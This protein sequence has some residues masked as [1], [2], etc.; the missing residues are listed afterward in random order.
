MIK[1]KGIIGTI[2]VSI[3][4][5]MTVFV[6]N[7][8]AQCDA[9]LSK[10][11]TCPTSNLDATDPA[12]DAGVWSTSGSAG[13]TTPASPSSQVT[14]LVV[15]TNT[16]TWTVAALGCSDQVDIVFS[17]AFAGNDKTVCETTQ[18]EGSNPSPGTGY[19][20]SS[21]LSVIFDDSTNPTA[22]VTN[23]PFGTVT[24]TW[25]VTIEGCTSTDD[26]VI[27]NS[28]PQ[29]V[30][31]GVS[32]E[33][34]ADTFQLSA[35]DPALYG[36]TGQWL[37]TGG[38]G[39][40][41]NSTL[42]NT[43]VR[44]LTAGNNTFQWTESLNGCP[45]S[46]LVVITYNDVNATASNQTI[47]NDYVTL[48]GNQPAGTSGLWTVI[49]STGFINTPTLRNTD[50][51]GLNP[52]ANT[53]KWTLTKGT[54]SDFVD[55]TI[56][57]DALFADAGPDQNVC[58]GTTSLDA[59]PLLS[60]ETGVWSLEVGFGSVT[61]VNSPSSTVTGISGLSPSVFRWSVSRAGCTTVWDEVTVVCDSLPADAGPD[62]L[63]LCVASTTLQALTGDPALQG[64]S[65]VWLTSS[66]ATI[67]NP[68]NYITGVTD[69]GPG[70][71]V[72]HWTVTR[73]NC[74]VSDPVTVTRSNY[75]AD[76][77]PDQTICGN[78][79]A[80]SGSNPGPGGTGEWT[81]TSGGPGTIAD[82]FSANT[83]ISNIVSFPIVLRWTV[84][85]TCSGYDEMTITDQG[86]TQAEITGNDI[87]YAGC[88]E[89][90]YNGLDIV[91]PLQGGEILMWNELTS[92]GVTFSNPNGA[93]T[94]VTNLPLPGQTQIE[95]II[96][97]G[98]CTTRDTITIST[99]A[100]VTADAG[101]DIGNSTNCDQYVYLN[102][103]DPAPAV[104]TWSISP[105]DP[106]DQNVYIDN[107]NDPNTYVITRAAVP[108]D[109]NDGD[110]TLVWTVTNGSCTDSDNINIEN[111]AIAYA[112]EDMMQCG[113]EIF[114]MNAGPETNS[115][116]F[117]GE[118]G[119]WDFSFP[120][121][122]LNSGHDYWSDCVFEIDNTALEG[123]YP[124]IWT[125]HNK[126]GGSNT[127]VSEDTLIMYFLEDLSTKPM[128][129]GADQTICGTT[130]TINDATVPS[131]LG[132][133][134][135]SVW[136]GPV[137][138]NINPINSPSTT[139]SNLALGNNFLTWTIDNTCSSNSAQ[140]NILVS[141][142]SGVD[143][144]NDTIICDDFITLNADPLGPSDDGTWTI[145]SGGGF[146]V[147]P[148]SNTTNVTN[149]L[150]GENI[151]KWSV[152]SPFCNSED[153]VVI[154]S[155]RPSTPNAGPD[156]YMCGED[157]MLAQNPTN[158]DE[159]AEW[160]VVSGSATIS[161]IND[162]NALVESSPGLDPPL[163]STLR[164]TIF[165]TAPNGLQCQEYDEVNV[166]NYDP[167]I[168]DA[169]IDQTVCDDV[170]MTAN[171]PGTGEVGNWSFI[172][173]SAVF[174]D[175]TLYNTVASG[176]DYTQPNLLI[177]RIS[178]PR[179]GAL[180]DCELQD[181]VQI[182]SNVVDVD[183]GPDKLDLC[184]STHLL[185][186]N[187][188]T[189]G[190]GAW[191]VTSGNG[192][193]SSN[194]CNATVSNLLQGTNI[195]RW[196]ITY[197]GCN[198]WDEVTVINNLPTAPNAGLDKTVCGTTT[199]AG[200]N[201]T[202][203][204][205]TWSVISGGGTFVDPS[206]NNTV[207]NGL[208]YGSNLMV[209]TIDN[210]SCQLKDTVNITSDVVGADAGIDETVCSSSYTLNGNDPTP[211]TGLWTP[212]GTT[213][214]ILDPTNINSGVTGMNPGP[215]QFRWTISNNAC[216]TFDDVIIINSEPTTADAGL[217][218][219]VCDPF[220]NLNGNVAIEGTGV[221]TTANGSVVITD[222]TDPNS[223]VSN[224]P[225]AGVTL[226]TWTITKGSC[227][228]SDDVQIQYVSDSSSAGPDQH[229]C[230]DQTT[231]D[232]ADPS[233]G[234]GTWSLLSGNPLTT[235]ADP[236]LY[237]TSVTG[238]QA[239]E[240]ILL[241]SISNGA[242]C[243][244]T[245]TVSIFNDGPYP[246]NAGPDQTVCGSITNL[247]ATDLTVGTGVWSTASGGVTIQQNTLYNTLVTG[248]PYGITTFTWTATEGACVVS[249]NVIIQNDS[250]DVVNGE[251]DQFSCDGTDIICASTTA[252]GSSGI[253]D[254]VQGQ[255]NIANPNSSCT[256]VSSLGQGRNTFRWTIT[257]GASSCVSYNYVN[258]YNL[259][260]TASAGNDTAICIDDVVLQGNNPN[261]EFIPDNYP[262][263][264]WWEQVPSTA[265]GAIQNPSLFNT[266]VLGI[267]F[268]SNVFRWTVSNGY[269]TDW[270]E[271]TIINNRPSPADAGPDSILC[272]TEITLNA[273]DPSTTA[274]GRGTGHWEILGGGATLVNPT[275][276]NS[277]V[278][279]L[280]YL[281]A[282]YWSPDW[283]T[284][285][286]EVNTFQW[287]VE[288]NGC[289]SSDIV[290]VINGLPTP[291]DAGADQTVCANE[292]NMDAF[293]EG[294][295][296]QNHWWEAVSEPG[297]T[298]W[299][300]VDGSADN[301]DFNAHVENLPG[302]PPAGTVT[303]FVWHKANTFGGLTCEVTDTT[304]IHSLGYS[305]ILNA[306]NDDAVCNTDYT[307]SGTPPSDLFGP[308]DDVSGE[309]SIIYG[310]GNIDDITLYDSDVHD[311]FYN[312]NVFRWTITNNDLGCIMTDDVYIH[313]GLPS[314]ALCGSD[315]SVCE[316]RALLT[317]TRPIRGNG[318]WSVLVGTS[319][320]EN[321]SCQTFNCNTYANDLPN[322]MN[323]FLWTVTNTYDG[324]HGSYT[325]ANPLVCTL[326]DTLNIDNNMVTADAGS[327]IYI[328]E[329]T[330]QLSANL[331]VGESG[332]WLAGGSSTFN[333]TGT[334][335]SSLH[336]DI[337]RNL[338]RGRNTFLWTVSNGICNGS[339]Q[340]TVY[341][342]LPYPN[343]AAG[344][345]QVICIDSTTLSSN[346]I[347]RNDTWYDVTV[348]T[349]EQE[350]YSTQE[351]TVGS[352]SGTF[353]NSSSTTTSVTAIGQGN[354]TYFWNASYHFTD[355]TYEPTPGT[356]FTQTCTL[357]D[358]VDVY[359]NIVTAS[360]GS[361]SPIICGV[362]GPGAS[363][364]LNADGSQ[365]GLWSSVFGFGSTIVDPT[366]SNS[367]IIGMQNGDHVY[368]WTVSNTYNGTTCSAWDE[369]I[370][371]VR[372]PT[373]SVVS[374]PP[375]YEICEDYTTLQANLPV[376]GDG[377][378]KE[379]PVPS[380]TIDAPSSNISNVTGIGLGSRLFE[381]TIDYD[382]CTSKDTITV[383]NNMIL[384]D[385]DDRIDD[386]AALHVIVDNDT[387]VCT[388]V[389]QL[390]ATDPNIYNTG[391]APYPTGEWSVF[392]GTVTFDNNTLYNT[393]VRNLTSSGSNISNLIWTVSKG[394][395]TEVST[396]DIINNE[397]TVDADKTFTGD[398]NEIETCD[399]TIIL[400]GEQ[401][402][403]NPG[404]SG[405]WEVLSG[406]GSI[407]IPTL[408]N[409]TVTGVAKPFSEFVWNVT[410]DGCNAE[411]TVKVFNNSVTS[412][413]GID[414]TVC[415]NIAVLPG[416]Q[417]AAGE[418]G[419][420]F[421]ILGGGT[422]TLPS[423]Y[424]SGVTNLG[425]GQNRFLWRITKGNCHA[426]DT[427]EIV[428][429]EP[430]NF[431]VEGA[432]ESC[433]LDNTISVN[434][435]PDYV[436]EYGE[437][438]VIAGGAFTAVSDKTAINTDVT[439]LQPGENEFLWTVTKGK[440]D[441]QGSIVI[442]SNQVIADA[443]TLQK[444]C[445]DSTQL[446]AA[447]PETNYTK[448]GTGTWT[449]I[450][451]TS[452]I[453]DDTAFDSWVHDLD[454]GL[455]SFT[456][457]MRLGTCFHSDKVEVYNN[458]VTASASDQ[459]VCHD[460]VTLDGNV[461]PV[462]AKGVWTEV[463]PGTPVIT[464]E[465]L[466]VTTVTNLA[467]GNNTFRWKLSNT[468]GCKDSID[469][470]IDNQE[471]TISAGPDQ[472]GLCSTTT[473][474]N[475][476]PPG[477]GQTGQWSVL[478][479]T[480]NVTNPTLF[481]SGVTNLSPGNNKLSWV[482]TGTDC[483]AQDKVFI[484]NS[485][486][487]VAS[488][489]TPIPSNREVC[490]NSAAIEGSQ[491]LQGEGL[492][493]ADFGVV[494]FG[495][496]TLY[497]TT[498]NNLALGENEI[499]WTISNG[500]CSNS[501]SIVITNNEVVAVAGSDKTTG[502]TDAVTLSGN[503]P[504]LTQGSGVWTDQSGTTAV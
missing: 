459:T 460:Y 194:T 181:T 196:T 502:C 294:Q 366:N 338:T 341:D 138:V 376:W 256:T 164:W 199:M 486:P 352:G 144:G 463:A 497:Q 360:A 103:V 191:S 127:C 474:L 289:Q 370:I 309:W 192:V 209:W 245:D 163:F 59:T 297:V 400:N 118:Y 151:F 316:D 254:L 326:T 387:A 384:S 106:D 169:G 137:G 8:S 322:G 93:P 449:Q 377:T 327:N 30:N 313:N 75:V 177:W 28:T 258:V 104:G 111:Y 484:E 365:S 498:V 222:T 147:T 180:S 427:V 361:D 190:T 148:T 430:N 346:S 332:D 475:A 314:P 478:T 441:K 189:T 37:V 195:L 160:S 110:F 198:S 323:S 330:V 311:L 321:P 247:E 72:F 11:V 295:C 130:A 467:S 380:G 422:V 389:F 287:V 253:W 74:T 264:G 379:V 350:G 464:D 215:N 5:I 262:A 428:N 488:I 121:I 412:N 301:T 404:E 212:A 382:G 17:P 235:F 49:S 150:P 246:V 146:I 269:C 134:T 408:Y 397:F 155:N 414:D 296:A 266:Q 285:N 278:T 452:N 95:L 319:T 80:L 437:W 143:A 12:P 259:P 117:S 358:E 335:T 15:G 7:V 432:K 446:L 477:V 229:I 63:D 440:C 450:T 490:T 462:D 333:T 354:N 300:P 200:N 66:G 219:T 136:S 494:T 243:M 129:A 442:T 34:C 364:F 241:W 33:A 214:T 60:G 242:S 122:S 132:I 348:T 407:Q 91:N 344:A 182:L 107:P 357:T 126:L 401:P 99:G 279:N 465:T 26:V 166:Y 42:F 9:G 43:V 157:M 342:N 393:T 183:A 308:G 419:Q 174:A 435:A 40:F 374:N 445:A 170:T 334:N 102:A 46:D 359:N 216:S 83:S 315:S 234:T 496:K 409:T 281:C 331:N 228:S 101:A 263:W 337:V 371:P 81:I 438:S 240:T 381:W 479:G 171:P 425:Q 92:F 343:P 280:N 202:I 447:D 328:C 455:N 291:A 304:T 207:V 468:S 396:L 10:T 24:F 339:D 345:D 69:L 94:N 206:L 158:P 32:S 492:W 305:E 135:T 293:D 172:Q 139:V 4:L 472:P 173:G 21:D 503:D 84:N 112:G 185:D 73:N 454:P 386:P 284:T 187:C 201:P 489:T 82:V 76:A 205:G 68:S 466:N 483:N 35:T 133:L 115:H 369:V 51:Y 372:I 176:F 375:T 318:V 165:N 402:G 340:L 204:T 149:L 218:Q 141:G 485:L 283:W 58:G 406:G 312:T 114:K 47:C 433:T 231:L 62:Q 89:N 458:S 236:T 96:T 298:F 368:R 306:G 100:P 210:N 411:D 2:T 456:W 19:W 71:S 167:V 108:G 142:T 336:N 54:C 87:E 65:G 97:D 52:G 257:V 159:V 237:N 140:V 238:L 431:T 48:D 265:P 487:T 162:N 152:I 1:F 271:V 244:Y 193:F 61:S 178:A 251:I 252:Y 27:T 22:T 290:R 373:T 184:G 125:Y 378:W 161:D 436:F 415:T 67:V 3:I 482:V 275:L 188:P 385:A 25:H 448:Q 501:N 493:T 329:D 36:G 353:A 124:V 29:N 403:S 156:R 390:S 418:T 394:G 226:F 495:N 109:P 434:P 56:T 113:N 224:L 179:P 20:T 230:T 469:I 267:D 220:T 221:W 320:I 439:D 186:A 476:D 292:A 416:T 225:T 203:G 14:G 6:K 213:A 250:I 405:Y 249:E 288:Y 481:N 232:A 303:T 324:P 64:G 85:G 356:P 31:A 39:L 239:G 273:V 480:A 383:Y 398:N 13:I 78:S 175:N 473:T 98:V 272:N 470:I 268:D 423:L 105:L 23:L 299:D 261:G 451:G 317:A 53:F 233:P 211:G 410:R 153:T 57:Y 277:A 504:T 88:N 399:G 461:P 208:N 443:G 274:P 355:Y 217:D 413:A 500:T 453:D 417:P 270:D 362:E 248:L 457:T 421:Q 429:N 310:S 276:F 55:V 119:I 471:F 391:N 491:P 18:L 123:A 44:G 223:F 120:G 16:F 444:V 45:A 286:P 131:D 128:T 307:L 325:A 70:T 168:P 282:D 420:W 255:G 395:C 302:V 388:D 392:P 79:A 197:N 38:T 50:V 426:N 116:P 363:Y 77:G 424:N 367:Q 86:T 41:D 90:F 154:F 351:W 499:T 145:V 349:I 347:T 260:V 227:V